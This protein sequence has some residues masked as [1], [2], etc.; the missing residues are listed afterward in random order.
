[1]DNYGGKSLFGIYRVAVLLAL[2]ALPLAAQETQ[3]DWRDTL[4]DP[5]A[6]RWYVGL[7]GGYTNNHMVSSTGYRI[8]TEYRNGHGFTVGLPVRFQIFNW[9]ALQ[10]EPQILQKN[11]S[12]YRQ[13]NGLNIRYNWTNTFFDVPLYVSF[14]LNLWKGLGLFVN[15]GGY[16][17]VWAESRV[18]GQTLN[19]ITEYFSQGDFIYSSFDEKVSFD[20]DRDNRF[21][22][23]LLLGFGLHYA[24]SRF[25]IFAEG[26]FNYGLTDMQKAYMIDKVPRYNDTWVIQAGVLLN[27]GMIAESLRREE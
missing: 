1:M 7:S 2:L 19:P 18:K 12:L 6:Y 15:A 23:G 22:G 24:F 3:T 13:G 9:L 16:M 25:T 26:R 14:S 10:G 4:F 21:D 20:K 27:P 5:P 8:S 17:G 11:Y